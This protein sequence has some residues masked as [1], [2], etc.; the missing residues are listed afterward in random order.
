MHFTSI[1]FLF[2]SSLNKF[3]WGVFE[4]YGFLILE[5][6]IEYHYLSEVCFVKKF[7]SIALQGTLKS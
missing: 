5:I 2:E 3:D 7:R 6:V 4:I 1:R